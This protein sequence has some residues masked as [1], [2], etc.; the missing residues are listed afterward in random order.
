MESYFTKQVRAF[1]IYIQNATS[2]SSDKIF[3]D[4]CEADSEHINTAHFCREFL[5]C[6]ALQL[7]PPP[8]PNSV[9]GRGVYNISCS[10]IG[11]FQLRIYVNTLH[12]CS[13]ILAPKFWVWSK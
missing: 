11:Y 4:V 5:F 9:G 6:F 1:R 8:T 2:F 12:H 10:T 3:L 13:Y 7:S